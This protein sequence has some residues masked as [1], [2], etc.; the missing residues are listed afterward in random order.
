MK[1]S[2]DPKGDTPAKV[3][4]STLK[5]QWETSGEPYRDLAC[6]LC[7]HCGASLPITC[8]PLQ[9]WT[10][11]RCKLK[12]HLFKMALIPSSAVTFQVF[13]VPL[14]GFQCFSSC[15]VLDLTVTCVYECLGDG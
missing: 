14:T 4:S 3:N 8:A 15:R 12:V 2:R 7:V 1:Y 5:S 10:L 13:Q 11:Y 6:S 9:T